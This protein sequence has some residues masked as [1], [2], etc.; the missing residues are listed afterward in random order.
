MT[1]A[2]QRSPLVTARMAAFIGEGST[3]LSLLFRGAGVEKWRQR[4][5][6]STLGLAAA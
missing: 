5:G 2:S 4:A 1:T 6:S 3:T